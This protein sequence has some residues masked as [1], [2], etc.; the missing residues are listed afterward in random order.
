MFVWSNL[1]WS[2]KTC[3]GF[4]CKGPRLTWNQAG[5]T[6][7]LNPCR[8]EDDPYHYLSYGTAGLD[9]GRVYPRQGIDAYAFARAE[10][11]IKRFKLS[12]RDYLVRERATHI[13]RFLELVAHFRQFGSDVPGPSGV[14]IGQRL[15]EILNPKNTYLAPIRQILF[16]PA[17]AARGYSTLYEELRTSQPE[18]DVLL[19]Q[20]NAFP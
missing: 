2:C 10:Y 13:R 20:W 8:A 3:N 19:A 18:V 7:L 1:S 14:T 12:K 16:D 9:A 17:F 15:A 5:Q 4:G 11:T 6:Y